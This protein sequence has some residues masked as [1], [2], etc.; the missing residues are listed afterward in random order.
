MIID[1]K[2]EY[3]SFLKFVI[4]SHAIKF[5]GIVNYIKH[6][7]VHGPTIGEFSQPRNTNK[8]IQRS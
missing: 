4:N 6:I 3:F 7:A 2:G 1:N 8:K 5:V